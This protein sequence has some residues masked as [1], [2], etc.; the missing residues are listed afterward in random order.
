M[1]KSQSHCSIHNFSKMMI[2]KAEAPQT[3]LNRSI[4]HFSM[5][6]FMGPDKIE[7]SVFIVFYNLRQLLPL[8]IQ[9]IDN[10]TRFRVDEVLVAL[11]VVVLVEVL[12]VVVAGLDTDGWMAGCII[13]WWHDYMMENLAFSGVC[14]SM[15]ANDQRNAIERSTAAVKSL[16]AKNERHVHIRS[17][18]SAAAA[19]IMKSNVIVW[20]LQAFW[21]LSSWPWCS[22]FQDYGPFFCEC[23]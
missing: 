9:L 10:W 13:Q 12:V 3:E 16:E 15:K 21:L 1:A 5:L 14:H 19:T 6:R 20:F 18:G 23:C 22:L 4:W 2:E 11:V 7:A 8:L 17:S